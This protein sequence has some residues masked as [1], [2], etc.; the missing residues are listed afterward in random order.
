MSQE[1]GLGEKNQD[2]NLEYLLC[3]KVLNKDGD[4]S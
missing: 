1:V 2:E 4:M 3:Q